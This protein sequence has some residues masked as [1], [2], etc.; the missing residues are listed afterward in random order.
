MYESKFGFKT[1]S[2][3]DHNIEYDHDDIAKNHNHPKVAF[4]VNTN[5]EVETKYFDKDNYN[6]A[7]EYQLSFVSN[8]IKYSKEL[9]EKNDIATKSNEL[10]VRNES[11]E[12]NTS[13]PSKESKKYIYLY[14][15][16][17]L[18]HKKTIFF[19]DYLINIKNGEM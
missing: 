3:M 15:K 1:A 19:I 10:E 9:I 12:D 14:I 2:I 6:G 18:T 4:M 7:K 11:N 8:D 5:K 16:N 17:S 13:S